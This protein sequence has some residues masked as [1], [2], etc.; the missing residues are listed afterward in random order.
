MVYRW[1]RKTKTNSALP[2]DAG[3]GSG[4]RDLS[5]ANHGAGGFPSSYSG[6]AS[7][8]LSSDGG[9]RSHATSY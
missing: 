9:A 4:L 2:I 8:G 6:S 1:F 5:P 3:S 7:A